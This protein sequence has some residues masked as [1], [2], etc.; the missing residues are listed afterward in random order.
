MRTVFYKLYV[1]ASLFFVFSF[2][3]FGQS[4]P[5]Y[6]LPETIPEKKSTVKAQPLSHVAEVVFLGQLRLV[7]V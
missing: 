4:K 3:A 2:E 5:L 6:Q 7:P 1:L